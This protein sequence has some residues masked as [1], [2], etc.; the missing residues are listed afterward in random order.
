MS[1]ATIAR[2]ALIVAL[3]AA[4]FIARSRM[5][6][7]DPKNDDATIVS[8]LAKPGAMEALSWLEAAPSGSRTI[9]GGEKEYDQAAALRLVRELYRRGAAKVTAIGIGHDADEHGR[10][11]QYTDTLIVELP[12]KPEL[13]R[14]LFDLDK[15]EVQKEYGPAEEAGQKYFMMW[16]D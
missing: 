3:C 4:A 8:L 15:R 12:D 16:W 10:E 6:R 5:D 9:G 2:T 7:S 13:R 1:R 14:S 11:V